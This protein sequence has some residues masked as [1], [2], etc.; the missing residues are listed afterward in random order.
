M[1]KQELIDQVASAADMTKSDAASAVDVLLDTIT[2]A[3]KK[4][5][6][7]RLTGF[8]S[9]VVTKR[10]ASTGRNPRTGATVQI[11]AAN[12]PKFKAGKAL[13]DAVNG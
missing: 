9:F 7:V 1:N 8:G 5:D 3:L 13:K 6:D 11:P 10:A 2:G 4:G 12:V